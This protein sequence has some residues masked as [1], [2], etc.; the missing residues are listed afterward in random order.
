MLLPLDH[1]MQTPCAS[2]GTCLQMAFCG[3]KAS[4]RTFKRKDCKSLLLSAPPGCWPAAAL[5]SKSVLE[6]S[7]GQVIQLGRLVRRGER[8]CK[9]I[10][11]RLHHRRFEAFWN[12]AESWGVGFHWIIDSFWVLQKMFLRDPE[13]VTSAC[14]KQP[15]TSRLLLSLHFYI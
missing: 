8:G 7:L 3:T 12:L 2:V 15:C 1:P 4:G 9:E 10:A 13:F 14:E 11:S 5:L 6:V